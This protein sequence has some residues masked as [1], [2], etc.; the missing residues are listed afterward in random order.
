MLWC[1]RQK[2]WKILWSTALPPWWRAAGSA[3]APEGCNGLKSNKR[4][5]SSFESR[6]AQKHELWPSE[7]A[8]HFYLF[9]LYGLLNLLLH[10][11]T[12]RWTSRC[13]PLHIRQLQNKHES[14]LGTTIDLPR[15][16][17]RQISRLQ[18]GES[19]IHRCCPWVL[20]LHAV[21]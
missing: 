15:S 5:C 3:L 18:Y 20:P 7:K 2:M 1:M 19:L 10:R 8:S 11:L 4:E 13:V 12:L 21:F 9:I 17:L 6:L 16:A 14:P